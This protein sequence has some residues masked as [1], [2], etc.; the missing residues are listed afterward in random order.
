VTVFISPWN[1]PFSVPIPQMTGAL[2]AGNTAVFKPAPHSVL[3]GRKIDD[4]FRRAGFPEGVVQTLFLTDD[5]APYLTSHPG[6]DKIVFTGSTE[7]GKHVM[8]SA[9]NMSPV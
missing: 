2:L 6:V 4:C 5:D 9:A 3:I 8:T 7:V 1:F